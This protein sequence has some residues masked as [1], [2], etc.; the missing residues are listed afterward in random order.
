MSKPETKKKGKYLDS[1]SN[2]VFFLTKA[3]KKYVQLKSRLDF[4]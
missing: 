2:M 1:T 4:F 3:E